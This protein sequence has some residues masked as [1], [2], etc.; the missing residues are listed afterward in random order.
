MRR[1]SE[2]FYKFHRKMH[3]KESFLVKLSV[4]QAYSC[5]FCDIFNN[6]QSVKYLLTSGSDVCQ[7]A[8]IKNLPVQSPQK[9]T[10]KNCEICSKLTIKTPERRH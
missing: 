10:R 1:Y 6:S 5:E 2:K 3:G 7:Q 9:N 4:L 8:L